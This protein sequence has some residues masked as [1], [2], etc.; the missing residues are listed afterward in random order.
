[1]QARCF[2]GIKRDQLPHV[3]PTTAVLKLT[4]QT[5]R[6]LGLPEVCR[7]PSALLTVR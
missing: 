4:A 1:M 3:L 2:A 7:L 6:K 5:G